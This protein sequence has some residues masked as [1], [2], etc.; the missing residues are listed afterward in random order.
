MNWPAIITALVTPYDAA[1][2]VDGN[3][4]QRLVQALYADGSGGFVVA[5]STGEAYGLALDEREHLFRAVRAA[6]PADVPVWVGTGSNDTRE[7][8][9][10]TEAADRWGADG[11]LVVAPYYNKPSARGLVDHFVAA[12]QTT[13]RPIMVYDVPGRT[14]VHIDPAVVVEAH[15]QA[16]N[17]AAVKEAAGTITAMI[18]MHRALPSDIKLYSGDDALLLPSLAVGA[19]GVVSVAAHVAA[20]E[21]SQLVAAYGAGRAGDA[22]ALH[23]A[24]WP[25]NQALFVESNPVPL[26]W[27]LNRLGW[28]VGGVRPPLAM[29]EDHRLEALWNAY[30]ALRETGW[31]RQD[32]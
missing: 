29:P 17:I 9:R 11:M 31:E 23:E 1:G 27:L 18:A 4:A 30:Q 32:A 21:M 7:T 12:A 10:L 3:T 25:L 22:V 13:S 15:R 28:R 26:K 14:G 6:L 20:R 5:G 2:R 24:L 16:P 8:V 19:A